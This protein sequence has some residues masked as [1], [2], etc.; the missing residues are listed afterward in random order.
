M[1][2]H[3]RDFFP[4]ATE[5]SDII[6]KLQGQCK[7]I[8]DSSIVY[9]LS[10]LIYYSL[11]LS[12]YMS[13]SIYIFLSFLSSFFLLAFLL[14]VYLSTYLPICH[15]EVNRRY[16]VFFISKYFSGYF[17]RTRAFSYIIEYNF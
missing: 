1:S 15:F 8:L 5:N 2:L 4:L 14:S 17:L 12:L 13:T 6:S 16:Q 10:H 11:F 3:I 7:E 9:I